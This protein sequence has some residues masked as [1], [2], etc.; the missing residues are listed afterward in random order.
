[1]LNDYGICVKLWLNFDIIFYLHMVWNGSLS[2]V[3]VII[4]GLNVS[5]TYSVYCMSSLCSV[6]R[7]MYSKVICKCLHL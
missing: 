5:I 1:M 7:T 4:E 3:N 6:Y 2:F